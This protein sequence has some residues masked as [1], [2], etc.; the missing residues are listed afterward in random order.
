MFA[1][2]WHCPVSDIV[3]AEEAPNPLGPV[4]AWGVSCFRII[5]KDGRQEV[6]S[7]KDV[8]AAIAALNREIREAETPGSSGERPT[9]P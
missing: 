3:T 4:L 6:F 9:T 5:L 7:V 8:P 2:P 1:E